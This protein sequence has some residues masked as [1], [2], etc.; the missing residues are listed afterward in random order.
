MDAPFLTFISMFQ[1]ILA[2]GRLSIDTLVQIG[3]AG[4]VVIIAIAYTNWRRAVKAALVIALFEGALRKWV[5]PQGQELVYFFKDVVLLGAYLRFFFSPTPEMRAYTLK[6]NTT[7]FLVT[8][9]ILSLSAMSPDIGSV[10]LALYGIKIYL[11]YLPLLFMMPYLFTSAEDMRKNLVGFALFATPICLLGFAQWLRPG[12]SIFN[13]YAN[14]D[15]IADMGGSA[16]MIGDLQSRVRITG[17]FSYITGHVTFVTVFFALHVGLLLSKQPKWATL[18]LLC[19]LPL[20]LANGLMSGSRSAIL[21]I[22]FVMVGYLFFSLFTRVSMNRGV[23]V[24]LAAIILIGGGISIYSFREAVDRFMA[25]SLQAD[26]SLKS[27]LIYHTGDSMGFAVKEVGM[28]GYGIGLTHPAVE[29][30]RNVLRV[31]KPRT[32]PP[33]FD[34]EMSQIYVELGFVGFATWYFM[35]FF[36]LFKTFAAFR[37][38]QSPLLKPL[39][40]SSILIQFPYFVMSLVL[41]H[42]AGV[43]LFALCGLSFIPFLVPTAVARPVAQPHAQRRVSPQRL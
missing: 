42:T 6:A 18:W 20:L 3:L 41:N 10:I 37:I 36:L 14:Q 30:M 5:F 27:R 4:G 23:V 25:R 32:L 39:L 24:M 31:K 26:D 7:V 12:D 13:V 9:S 40:L 38:T 35:R 43:L 29:R 33:V 34:M 28:F 21:C 2:S 11:F 22:I 8:A 19:N 15:A 16:T 17:T 1:P